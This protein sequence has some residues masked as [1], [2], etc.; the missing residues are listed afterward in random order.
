MTA[1]F[2]SS[3]SEFSASPTMLA[4]VVGSP[5][6]GQTLPQQCGILVVEA[7]PQR[8]EQLSA[9]LHGRDQPV[10]VCT[11][12]LSADAEQ[13]VVW[14]RFNDSRLD[15]PVGLE[16]WGRT[17]PNLHLRGKEERLGCLLQDLLRSFVDQQRFEQPLLIDLV[18][19]QGDP[20]AALQGLGGWIQSVRRVILDMP[21][22][23]ADWLAR[24]DDW[25]TSK[26]FR[27]EDQSPTTWHRDPVATLKLKLTAQ[28]DELTDLRQVVAELTEERDSHLVRVN[29]LESR[30]QLINEELESIL[31]I[32]EPTNAECRENLSA[33]I[34][35]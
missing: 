19:R 34:S 23:P 16:G 3:S 30:L 12:V 9:D 31:G 24:V 11:E 33:Q 22:A 18:I 2:E 32:L 4:V 35:T 13:L 7:D 26:A 28:A 29:E 17:Y 27:A 8:A 6:L 1:P 21:K 10:K 5:R 25:L 14:N 20:M 15:G